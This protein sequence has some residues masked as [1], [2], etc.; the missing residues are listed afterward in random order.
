MYF[1][2]LIIVFLQFIA[3]FAYFAGCANQ[4]PPGG[5]E[6]DKTPPKVKIE[7]P[8]PN[9]VNFREKTINFSFNEY[10]DKRSFQDAFRISPAIKGDIEYNWSGNDV[11]VVFPE[12]LYKIEPNKTFV[13]NIST[14]LKDVHGNTISEPVNFAFSTGPV[15]DMGKISGSVFNNISNKPVSIFAYKLSGKTDY[16]PTKNIPDYLT[17]TSPEGRYNLTNLAP[18]EYRLI[19]LIDDDINL[20]F[21][22][23]RESYGVLAYDITLPDSGNIT[24]ADFYLSLV[25]SKESVPPE[26]DYTKYFRDSLNIVYSSVENDSRV[27]A[28]DQSIFIF[29]SSRKPGREEFINSAKITGEENHTEKLVFNWRNDSLVE[30]F[31]VSKF[32]PNHN[33]NLTFNVTLGKDSVYNYRLKFKTIGNNSFGEIRGSVRSNYSNI[34]LSDY[35]VKLDLEAKDILPVVKYL[36]DTRDTVFSLKNILEAEYKLFSFID[37]NNDNSF[38]YGYPYPFQ[39]SEPF[40]IYPQPLRVRGGWTIENVVINFNK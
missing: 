32:K 19:A 16:D 28:P 34:I 30:L 22:S 18:A 29:F 13:I 2:R 14:G 15:I 39:N 31:A 37:I 26:L 17:E 9:S 40:Y 21:T 5:G 23:E 8:N 24:G 12:E 33:Y 1:I 6:E 38:N 20:L 4:Q 10:I 27:V 35:N 7:S 36:F 25:T 3:F 11:E